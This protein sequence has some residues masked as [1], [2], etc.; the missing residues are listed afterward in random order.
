MIPE[1]IKA[2]LKELADVDDCIVTTMEAM[3][4]AVQ[5]QHVYIGF[6]EKRIEK[7]ENS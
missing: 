6:L 3:A 4:E 2:V 7:L 5:I 1:E